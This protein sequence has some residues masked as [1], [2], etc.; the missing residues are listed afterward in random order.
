MAPLTDPERLRH[1]QAALSQW[2]C[3][4]YVTWTRLAEEW[5]RTNLD[6]YTPREIAKLM[7]RHVQGGGEVDEVKECREQWSE[8]EFH[9]DFRLII[10]KRSLYIETRLMMKRD[11]DDTTIDVVNIHEA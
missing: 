7:W 8:H 10:N 2:D 5:V 11:I 3:T 6:G 9:H 1:Y 4:G